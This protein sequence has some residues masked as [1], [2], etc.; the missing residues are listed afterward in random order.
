MPEFARSL[1]QRTDGD[2]P[3]R[4]IF[5]TV[6]LIAAGLGCAGAPAGKAPDPPTDGPLDSAET[7]DSAAPAEQRWRSA[8]YPADWAPGFAVD[9]WALQ[10]FS[11]AGYGAGERPPPDLR[12]PPWSDRWVELSDYDVDPEG[13]RDSAPG[14]AAAIA[15]AAEAGGG[16]VHVPAG[17]YRLESAIEITSSSLFLLGD[18]PE[19]SRL[20]WAGVPDMSHRGHLSF[21]GAARSEPER[22]LTADG[23]AFDTRV[24]LDDAR[25]LAPGDPIHIGQL[26]SDAWVLEHGMDGY[27]AFSRGEWRPIYRRT[28]V[29]VN[30]DDHTVTIDVPLR[31]SLLVR[32][33][34]SVARVSGALREVGVV[35]LG[36]SD[37]TD[38]A[39]A[40]SNN[41]THVLS[42]AHVEDAII[43][44][45]A[46]FASPEGRG[47]ADEAGAYHLQ[48]S[49]LLIEASRRV[50]ISG[51]RLGFSQN[52]GGGGNGYLYELRQSN[53]V[54]LRDN[55]GEAGRHNFIQNWDFGTNGC[56][57]LRNHSRA[58][59]SFTSAT[60]SR[61]LPAASETHH[62]LSTANLFDSNRIDDAWKSVNRLA[63]S[64]GAGHTATECVYWN[65]VGE[66]EIT[67]F[68]Y[69][70]GYVIGGVGL[71]V[72]TEVL[73]IYE[74]LGTSP[75]DWTEGLD[76]GALLDPPSLYE[77]QLN[78]R[79]RAT[80]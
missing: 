30:L 33:G 54:L 47:P 16:V 72:N 31:D 21:R 61:G 79:T 80:E 3:Q 60:D 76:A 57:F 50:T 51:C 10:D 23:A 32:D 34:A 1:P 18:G 78:R 12:A 53:D 68:Q 59:E 66:G 29:D 36:L 55:L 73:E 40:W 22:L 25:G 14:L 46:S 42:M 5:I 27:W 58:A 45:V 43:D 63:E 48:S 38:W 26:I 11:Y 71:E 77:D 13:V 49:G 7:P 70:R 15:A 28:V 52:R 41:Q 2:R 24:Q 8:L 20:V 62:A 35:G 74:S 17:L 64:S 6:L 44:D 37:A 75:E 69:G 4:S 67:S 65:N 56:V 19:H 9:G 39:T